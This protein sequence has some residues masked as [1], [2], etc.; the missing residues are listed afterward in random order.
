[1]AAMMMSNKTAAVRTGVKS[2]APAR[3][4]RL[5]LPLRKSVI[6][7]VQDQEKVSNRYYAST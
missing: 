3:P 7:R 2:A 4:G 1:M 6:V 5:A